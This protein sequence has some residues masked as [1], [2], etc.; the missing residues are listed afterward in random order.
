MLL[1]VCGFAL[2]GTFMI[3]SGEAHM[4]A[5]HKTVEGLAKSHRFY[6][7]TGIVVL[8]VATLVD[9]HFI[10]KFWVPIYAVMIVMLIICAFILKPDET[11]TTR[12]IYI[13]P[14]SI[15]P[16][17]FA[18]LMLII[19]L[20]QFLDKYQEKINK[21]GYLA[22]ALALVAIP[23][24]LV[25]L[26]PALSASLVLAVIGLT[27]I[28]CAKIYFRYII[29]AAMTLLIG[30]GVFVWDWQVNDKKVLSGLLNPYHVE[31]IAEYLEPPAKESGAP[32]DQT[33]MSLT[34]VR[35][36]L[37][38]G[39]GY[40]NG[41]FV[42]YQTN[43]FIFAT[44]A[45]EFGFTGCAAALVAIFLIVMKCL[46]TAGRAPDLMGSLIASGV[47]GMLAFQ[48]FVNVGVVTAIIPNTGM[49]FPFLSSGGS[50]LWIN[51]A[52]IGLVLNVGLYKTKSI[53]EG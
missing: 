19:S 22:A 17:E 18:K 5:A 30:A 10:A 40:M 51:L 11:K 2:F 35:A 15:Q 41:T 45:E 12:W 53:F 37:L 16:S 31:R 52:A 38:N 23:V 32:P 49:P 24:V 50:A 7:A 21:I 1:L 46:L 39:K 13:G 44:L 3:S 29:I 34:V 42:P 14:I 26:Q 25:E 4:V 47:A 48:V 28:F 43:D 36:G 8:A 6:F 27:M 20:S 9:Y 33:E